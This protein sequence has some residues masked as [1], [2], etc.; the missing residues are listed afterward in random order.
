MQYNIFIEKEWIKDDNKKVFALYLFAI[1]KYTNFVIL[2][3]I[4][5]VYGLQINSFLFLELNY[6]LFITFR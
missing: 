5:W 6:V 1:I 3:L 2:R 4:I